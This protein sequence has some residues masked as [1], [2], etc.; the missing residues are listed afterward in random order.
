MAL[1]V[2]PDVKLHIPEVSELR[3]MTILANALV[4]VNVS[5]ITI[6]TPACAD[7]EV[8]IPVGVVNIAV[9]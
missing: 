3:M 6:A 4:N 8:Q 1:I 2:H 5:A 7:G 9:G